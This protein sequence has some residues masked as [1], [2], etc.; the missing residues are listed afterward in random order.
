MLS[1]RRELRRPIR[2]AAA[3]VAMGCVATGCASTGS[4]DPAASKPA[5]SSSSPS[6]SAPGTTASAR[7]AGALP[8]SFPEQQ[9]HVTDLPRAKGPVRTALATYL[10]FESLVRDSLRT[11]HV[12]PRLRTLTGTSLF[13]TI[14]ASA[15]NMRRKSIV[16]TGPTAVA[17]TGARGTAHVVALNLCIDVTRTRQVVDGSAKPLDGPPRAAARS[18][19]TD[20]GGGWRVT[21]YTFDGDAC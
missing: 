15:A 9:L 5:T 21:E 1:A 12:S 7:H 17:V 4:D 8:T 18:V 10:E 11:H 19:L 2:A 6:P 16:E 14:V 20:D 13:H 3:V